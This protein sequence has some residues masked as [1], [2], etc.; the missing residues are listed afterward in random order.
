MKE[1]HLLW[2]FTLWLRVQ[3]SSKSTLRII[4]KPVALGFFMCFHGIYYELKLSETN[5]TSVSLFQGCVWMDTIYSCIHEWIFRTHKSLQKCRSLILG[6]WVILLLSIR[7][8]WH[9]ERQTKEEYFSL[10]FTKRRWG[11]WKVLSRKLLLSLSVCLTN[12]MAS[13]HAPFPFFNTPGT[14]NWINWVCIELL[15]KSLMTAHPFF[16]LNSALVSWVMVFSFYRNSFVH[17]ILYPL[18]FLW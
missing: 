8:T 6:Y 7:I 3:S 2:Y 12:E 15:V 10:K 17:R 11:Q 1:T 5:L 16:H 9:K 18:L 4:S 13:P 14:S